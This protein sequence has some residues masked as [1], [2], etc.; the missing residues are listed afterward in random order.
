MNTY[1]QRLSLGDRLAPNGNVISLTAEKRARI[2]KESALF[3]KGPIPLSW[4]NAAKDGSQATMC[5]ALALLFA[6]GIRGNH[7]KFTPNFH[8]PFS[9]P[10]QS[11]YRGLKRLEAKG[12]I[13]CVR[14][15][16]SSP[17]ITILGGQ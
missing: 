7:F 9:L 12:L 11:L 17:V 4:I 8:K 10:R 1:L 13:S 6:R 16:G 14:K 3:I 5:V 15:R 2:T